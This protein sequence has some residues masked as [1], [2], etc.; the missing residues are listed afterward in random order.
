VPHTLNSGLKNAVFRLVENV[1]E[2]R[3]RAGVE[4]LHGGCCCRGIAQIGAAD[5][6]GF[7]ASL[8][9]HGVTARAV[10]NINFVVIRD[11]AL[12]YHDSLAVF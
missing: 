7:V 10:D 3:E 4:E 11:G 1:G 9:R 2:K 12:A 6:A 5:V 8:L